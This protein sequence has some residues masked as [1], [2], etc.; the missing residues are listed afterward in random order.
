LGLSEYYRVIIRNYE[1]MNRPLTHLA[2]K[3]EHFKW[4]DLQQQDF[5]NLKVALT[6][7]SVLAHPRFD[8]PFILSTEA[9][10]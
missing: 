7:D 5:D 2:K 6:S 9:S 10:D 3:N 8:Q 4:T 1:A